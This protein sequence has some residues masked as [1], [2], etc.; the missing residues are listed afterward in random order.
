MRLACL[1]LFLLLT[2]TQI[3]SAQGPVS[4]PVMDIQTSADANGMGDI[5]ASLPSDNATATI[6]N[7]AQLGIFSL[8]GFVN[9][10]MYATKTPWLSLPNYTDFTLNAS[11]ANIG[12]NLGKIFDSPFH[13]SV[14]AGYSRV[15]L[16]LK[17]I[18]TVWYSVLL[19][20]GEW[21]EKQDNYTI[22][23]GVD[24]FVK[25]GLGYNFKTENSEE[26]TPDSSGLFHSAGNKVSAHDYGMMVQIPVLDI[27]SGFA[28]QP[29]MLFRKLQPVFDF[30]LGYARRNI[31]GYTALPS[32]DVS[33]PLPCTATLGLN[34]ELGL[35]TTVENRKW[36][37]FSF[38]WAREA[39]DLLISEKE[40][41]SPAG[42]TS[43]EYD[44]KSGIG[45]IE[46]IDNLILGRSYGKV[47]LHKGWQVQL[48]DFL[49]IRGGKFEGI[50]Y[51]YSTFGTS[52]ELNGLLK[53]LAAFDMLDIKH[54]T[55]GFL[56][57][58]FNL[59]YHFSEY[60]NSVNAGMDGTT[61]KAINLVIK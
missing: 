5:S 25:L 7:P 51:S 36:D 34:L 57:D 1:V 3:A 45:D 20:P 6:A 12:I 48:A 56:V 19:C 24:W 30:N 22:G 59:Q 49:Y 37:L 60:T 21:W 2:A 46:P 42:S 10:S 44:Y 8:D 27:A 26:P 50:G 11:A 28:E 39:E 43:Y 31:G 54:G 15:F 4:I 29:I 16:D 58:H 9:A 23:V 18:S 47:D 32:F 33:I 40:I 14:G 61:F 17:T 53:L 38:V 52:I 35:K 13:C 41:I 55:F